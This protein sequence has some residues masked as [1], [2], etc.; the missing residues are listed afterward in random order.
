[1][2][3]EPL[4]TVAIACLDDE[5]SIEACVR[6]AAG[7]G[8]AP[9]PARDR[10]RR[11]DEHR[12]HPRDPRPPRHRRPAHP[13]RRQPRENAGCGA[14]RVHPPGP[15]I[16]RRALRRQ[17]PL[18]ARF[19][20]P[21][22]RRPRPHRGGHRRRRGPP[23]RADL[24]PT[25][26]GR[27]PAEPFGVRASS[28]PGSRAT[29][30]GAGGGVRPGAFRRAVFERVGLFDPRAS[31]DEDAE[32]GRRILASG[33]RVARTGELEADYV[34]GASLRALAKKSFSYG[35]G[36]ARTMLKHGRFSTWGPALP[37]LWLVGEVALAAT[38]PRRGLPWS[39]G[40]Y[41]LATGAEA[42]RVGRSEGSAG[43]AGRVGLL[44]PVLHAA[45][46]AGFA[47]GLARA[48]SRARTGSRQRR[49]SRSRPRR[50]LPRPPPGDDDRQAARRRDGHRAP[51]A[52]H[53][54]GR[55]GEAHLDPRQEGRE[56][57]LHLVEGEGHAD[58]APEAAPERQPLPRRRLELEEPVG[59]EARRLGVEL[60]PPVHEVDRRSDHRAGGERVAPDR[61]RLPQEAPDER[62]DRLEPKGLS[63]PSRRAARR[64]RG[65][66]GRPRRSR[67]RRGG[68]P[69]A[70]ARSA[71][72]GASTRA[73]GSPS[74]RVPRRGASRARRAPRPR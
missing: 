50:C 60:G 16:G 13:P 10:R 66:R 23:P 49:P 36:R 71:A 65:A 17:G 39:L 34:P 61:L 48:T 8:V 62:H 68:A 9:R 45:H 22:R 2:T 15:G 21:V 29:R 11:R 73:R 59:E 72:T 4:V 74:S 58:A 27:R 12:R 38:S 44:F 55:A 26:R 5:S 70:T 47:S 25:L 51:C 40:A 18:R 69:R 54:A 14:E 64:G 6:S 56:H 46:G 52:P 3:N 63:H 28:G 24:P 57:H 32:M 1:M 43:R 67:S 30:A 20:P 7:A 53:L 19:R 41:A 42:I 33:G 37:L 31:A 35:R